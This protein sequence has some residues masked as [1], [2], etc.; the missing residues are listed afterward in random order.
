MGRRR[1][2]GSA[3]AIMAII[4]VFV[5]LF[6][7][8]TIGVFC[9]NISHMTSA[10]YKYGTPYPRL[11][12]EVS[13]TYLGNMYESNAQRGYSYYQLDLPVKNTG[14]GQLEPEYDLYVE[15]E[16]TEYDDVQEYYQVREDDFAYSYM[17]VIPS[18]LSGTVHQ[19]YL[20]RDG[21]EQVTVTLYKDFED[22]YDEVNGETLTVAV[23]AADS[24]E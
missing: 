1:K 9:E 24:A 18:G 14:N 23:P 6:L 10:D 15:V 4:F 7:I 17:E 2:G 3:T 5:L 22:Y 13:L 16:G 19:V 21:V 8:G 11:N 20:V 12:G